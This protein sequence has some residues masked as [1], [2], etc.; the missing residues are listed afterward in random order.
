[1]ALHESLTLERVMRAVEAEESIGFCTSCG[2]E[3]DGCEPDARGYKCD[4][5]GLMKVY[6][7]EEIF[8]RMA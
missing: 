7:A 4:S 3:R 2:E 5:C 8:L 6:G 1:M